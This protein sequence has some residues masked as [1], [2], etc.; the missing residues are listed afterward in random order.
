MADW[1][2]K[3]LFNSGR[4]FSYVSESFAAEMEDRPAKLAF[5]LNVVTLLGEHNLA[6]RYLRSVNLALNGWEYDVIL[7][8][9]WLGQ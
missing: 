6:W 1:M 8:L 4:T 9:D 2:A 5:H 7:G 3:V